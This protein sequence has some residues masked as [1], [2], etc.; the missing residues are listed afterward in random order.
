MASTLCAI[1]FFV[2][3]PTVI[4]SSIKG[5]S[6]V[7]KILSKMYIKPAWNGRVTQKG[8]RGAFERTTNEDTRKEIKKA[9]M[10]LNI[11][12]KTL[13][14]GFTVYILIMLFVK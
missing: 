12:D 9:I 5:H 8:L 6:V 7:E 14:I 13:Y 2:M 3:S 1:V 10:L 4:Y 11:A